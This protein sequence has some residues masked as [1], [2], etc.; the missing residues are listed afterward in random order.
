VEVGYRNI[1]SDDVGQPK[2]FPLCLDEYGLHAGTTSAG[3]QVLIGLLCPYVAVYVFSQDG[4]LLGGQRRLWLEPA[5]RMGEGGPYRI[6]DPAF[7]TAVSRQIREWQDELAFT[8]GCIRVQGF[9]DPEM[10]AGIEELPEH[11]QDLDEEDEDFEELQEQL[12]DWEASGSFVF[13][14]GKEYFMSRDGEVEST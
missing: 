6:Y 12:A 3:T 8:A 7:Q 9:S 11:L 13:H 10:N 5:P 2:R 14:W 4:A 1:M